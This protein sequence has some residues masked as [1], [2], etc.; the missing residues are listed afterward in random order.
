MAVASFAIFFSLANTFSLPGITPYSALKSPSISTPSLLLGRSLMWPQEASTS[1]PFPKYLLMVFAF[2]GDSTMTN[3]FDN[4]LTL[5]VLIFDF[6]R[7]RASWSFARLRLSSSHPRLQRGPE[8]GVR[9]KSPTV[10]YVTLR[11]ISTPK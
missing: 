8:H 1:K 10:T 7:Q 2:V 11:T 5:N 9:T 4:F 3:D 6:G